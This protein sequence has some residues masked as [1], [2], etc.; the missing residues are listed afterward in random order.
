MFMLL[1]FSI[2]YIYFT[3]SPIINN[4]EKFLVW[5]FIVV[6]SLQR[7]HI[8]RFLFKKEENR[9][10]NHIYLNRIVFETVIGSLIVM[11]LPFEFGLSSIFIMLIFSRLLGWRYWEFSLQ[12]PSFTDVVTWFGYGLPIMF[13]TALPALFASYI[14]SNIA[15][16]FPQLLNFIRYSSLIISIPTGV[17]MVSLAPRIFQSDLEGR[18]L[19]RYALNRGRNALLISFFMLIAILG[20]SFV[21]L[22]YAEVLALA[23]NL[24][25]TW[26][27]GLSLYLIKP[28]EKNNRTILLALMMSISLIL[29]LSLNTSLPNIVNFL[30]SMPY[31]IFFMI[32]IAF[33]FLNNYVNRND[34]GNSYA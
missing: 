30:S 18:M 12:I 19:Q 2:P 20:I 21:C 23:V 32:L 17:Q 6:E 9:I 8:T 16:S 3:L 33:N 14:L 31:I 26:L 22:S 4:F 34:G 25:G 1:L 24:I 29:S 27:W 7:V 5:I 11:L 13:L 10:L 28:I 15:T